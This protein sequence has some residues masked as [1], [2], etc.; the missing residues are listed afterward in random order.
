VAARNRYDT[1]PRVHLWE[2]N[3]NAV[4]DPIRARTVE[5]GRRACFPGSRNE[6]QRVGSQLSVLRESSW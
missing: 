3:H 6:H 5:Q 4:G 2:V 1:E